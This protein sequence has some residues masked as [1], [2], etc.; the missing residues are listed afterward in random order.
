M[1]TFCTW[2]ATTSLGQRQCI[3]YI[4][5]LWTRCVLLISLFKKY[6][7]SG[8]GLRLAAWRVLVYPDVTK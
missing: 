2:N 1:Q 7:N 3:F 8:G 4:L 6:I 5:V